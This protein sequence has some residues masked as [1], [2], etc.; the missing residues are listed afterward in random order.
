MSLVLFGLHMEW[1]RFVTWSLRWWYRCP[2]LTATHPYIALWKVTWYWIRFLFIMLTISIGTEDTCSIPDVILEHIFV[3][4]IWATLHDPQLLDIPYPSGLQTLA[5]I[6]THLNWVHNITNILRSTLRLVCH[7]WNS[8]MINNPSCWKDIV[9]SGHQRPSTLRLWMHRSGIIPL[10]MVLYFPPHMSC[11][12]QPNQLASS[13]ETEQQ[14]ESW[15]IN[16]LHEITSLNKSLSSITF[17][18][19]CPVNTEAV[20]QH[21]M[22]SSILFQTRT[23]RLEYTEQC[24]DLGHLQRSTIQRFP[25]SFHST[26]SSVTYLDLSFAREGLSILQNWKTL[27]QF[28][29]LMPGLAILNL[30][31]PWCPMVLTQDP[32]LLLPSLTSLSLT[33]FDTF[34]A[35]IF[36]SHFTAPSLRVLSLSLH[37]SSLQ[38]K[39]ASFILTTIA[40][41][42]LLIISQP[43]SLF[44]ELQVLVLS[45]F[46]PDVS[47]IISVI[48]RVTSLNT[49]ILHDLEN[50]H[51]GTSKFLQLFLDLSQETELA[52]DYGNQPFVPFP[53]L[54]C[55]ITY[56]GDESILLQLTS[57]RARLGCPVLH[58]Q[59]F[60]VPFPCQ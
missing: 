18:S 42:E 57:S 15:C 45:S 33:T 38:A 28:L 20:I 21:F 17:I 54:V 9:F 26:M 6:T 22:I 14:S 30:S 40:I 53:S 59:N 29:E 51:N 24:Q 1:H 34:Y 31:V 55:L 3:Q 56:Q 35:A 36:L 46:P 23:V 2:Y 41:P 5:P 16:I 58:Q 43:V 50:Q 37:S 19:A 39:E 12:F 48:H 52:R 49:L 4:A 27:L 32:V 10:N 47:A 13:F 7:R 11:I 44:P 60:P 8:V 25:K